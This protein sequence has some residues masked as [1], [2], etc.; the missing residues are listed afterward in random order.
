MS[1]QMKQ[2]C[3]Q[4]FKMGLVFNGQS[5]VGTQENNSDINFHHTEM[6][7]DSEEEWKVKILGVK[8]ELT[9]RGIKFEE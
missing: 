1:E 9:R 6:L 7:C 2:R 3:D 5:Y 4:L 8:A